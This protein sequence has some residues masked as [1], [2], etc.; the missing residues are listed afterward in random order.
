MIFLDEIKDL[1]LYNKKFYLPIDL[2]N[3]NTGSV[4][5]LLG[6]QPNQTT[7]ILKNPLLNRKYFKSY[8]IEKNI[9]IYVNNEGYM[10]NKDNLDTLLE[11]SYVDFDYIKKCNSIEEL[12]KM[13]E[14]FN[15]KIEQLDSSEW[16]AATEYAYGC[17]YIN[18]RKYQL[19]KENNSLLEESA[20]LSDYLNGEWTKEM[21]DDYNL[22]LELIKKEILPKGINICKDSI[23]ESFESYDILDGIFQMARQ[24][25][26]DTCMKQIQLN[27]MIE[28]ESKKTFLLESVINEGNI[29]QELVSD[30]F[31]GMVNNDDDYIF[32][33]EF[34]Q[35]NN[36]SGSVLFGFNDTLEILG[37]NASNNVYSRK[38]YKMLYNTRFKTPKEVFDQYDLLQ[39]SFKDIKYTY[40]TLD[41]Y[42]NKNLLLDLS[43][44]NS[45][46]FRTNTFVADKGINFYIDYLRRLI[47]DKRL[48]NYKKKTVIIPLDNSY[49]PDPKRKL[50]Y[51]NNVNIMSSFLRLLFK[52]SNKLR[53]FKDIDFIVLSDFGYFKFRPDQLIKQNI[54][55]FESLF[56]KLAKR[57]PI[58]DDEANKDSKQAMIVKVVD[59]LEKSQGI[60][61]HNLT[62]DNKDD[63][64]KNDLVNTIKKAV[65]KS[66]SS[67]EVLDNIEDEEHAKKL[68]MQA[69]ID[70]D[71]VKI[72]A[73]RQARID[74]N[75]VS[76]LDL[77]VKGKTVKDLL[78]ENKEDKE[79]PETKLEIDTINE[80][81]KH[82]KFDNFESVY[83]LNADIVEMLNDLA[84]KKY[85]IS[86]R[87]IKVEDTSTSEDT[88]ET[89]NVK[90]EDGFGKRFT[91]TFD[92]PKIVDKKYMYLRGN[93]KTI[94]GQLLLLPV[95]KTDLD[96]VQI[97]SNYK[98][99]FIRRYGLSTPG[100]TFVIADKIIKTLNK[101][102]FSELRI[103]KGNNIKSSNKYNLPIDYIDLSSVYSIIDSDKYT[104][105]F[106]QDTIY[107]E[108]GDIIKDGK[109]IP[110]GIDKT[111][112]EPIILYWDGTSG[113]C[114]GFISRLLSLSCPEFSTQYDKQK[115]STKYY[116]SQASILAS[117][118]PLIIVLAYSEGL[119][120]V[121]DKSK[122]KYEFTQKRP[123]QDDLNDVIRFNDGY[124]L[125]ENTPEASLLLNGLKECDTANYSIVDVNKKSM[126]LDFLD[127]FGGRI[128]ADG[129]DNFYELMIDSVTLDV[130]K[131][132]K[133]PTDYVSL[134]LYGNN[135]LVDNKYVMHT[136]LD[137]NRYRR[138]EIIAGYFYLCLASAYGDYATSIKKGRMDPMTIKQSAVIDAIMLDT[139]FGDKSIINA[140]LDVEDGYV[141]TT[142]GLSGMN[143]DRSYSLD[144]R[145]YNKSMLNIIALSTGFAGNVGVNRQ[146][147]ID[148][149]VEGKRGYLKID[150]N[151]DKMNVTKSLCL[152]E[153]LNPMIINSDD[154][155]RV[156]MG[157]I[158]SSKHTMRIKKGMPNLISNGADMALPYLGTDTFSF[159]AKQDGKIVE[160]NKEYMIVQYSDK[161]YDYISLK[162]NIEKNS[163][164]GVFIGIK[165]DTDLKVGQKFKTKDVLAYD[166][167]SFSKMVGH[168]G[169]LAYSSQLVPKI[170]IMT[171]DEGFE[172]ST[173]FSE[174]FSEAMAHD[175][176]IKKEITIPK[177][178]NILYMVK[179]GQPIKEG[180]SLI[181]FQDAYEDEDINILLKN[182]S[183]DEQEIS[184][185]GRIPIQS[186][187]EGT[188][189]DIKISRTVEKTE[190]SDS[191]RKVVN[192][193]EKPIKDL[194]STLNKY[195][196]PS[197]DKVDADYVLQNTGKLKNVDEGLLIEIFCKYEDKLSIGD[198]IVNNSAVKGVSKGIFPKG[199]EPWSESR[200]NEPIHVFTSV[201]G[202]SSRIV[203]SIMKVGGVNK[204][205]IELDRHVKEMAGIEWKILDD[206]LDEEYKNN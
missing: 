17:G 197:T 192:D 24:A 201:G 191:I 28:A 183:S 131:R 122:I 198:K 60:K 33:D 204:F 32:R 68:I 121:L 35:F 11:C 84:N 144:K 178:A 172:D 78:S 27:K 170:A 50:N 15:K 203:T 67:E 115:I 102:E 76:F 70:D 152:T 116:Y 30:E 154:P 120:K 86:V 129:L 185:M 184:E 99:I 130:L 174:W 55:K 77:D 156:L 2:K 145:T 44:Y 123:Q 206:I 101:N 81:W 139:T 189:Q 181:I 199:E 186:H 23:K 104:I 80:E 93:R 142:K 57:E 133:L 163:N 137:S 200:P 89:W 66:N 4:V 109:G 8:Y 95:S 87:D 48:K 176:I 187:V 147:T 155:F 40:L 94:S 112:K 41:K 164:G 165:L 161:S 148:M 124:L 75:K 175:I 100:K 202:L 37:E 134:L 61:I 117:K 58:I 39:A 149:N 54:S 190:L 22:R 64:V 46:F 171:T 196:I 103:S 168:T 141:V 20:N 105:Y 136:E 159:K 42:N 195:N 65:D 31:I 193:Y 63:V 114:S 12:E 166:R 71:P 106:N 5:M 177:D 111:S 73:T 126:Y 140:S 158:Q 47:M 49:L 43:Y 96:T 88:I 151:T 3:K 56:I 110:I 97:V 118:I 18:R 83:D 90:M 19:K 113:S 169:E 119:I 205:I 9:S 59:D 135:L 188:I 7:E 162:E 146:G 25:Q 91:F 53:Q 92:I 62:G 85:P 82:L 153:A 74:A 179:K 132:Y 180:E 26:Y 182:L 127:I 107:K 167:L 98:K 173:I 160:L 194:K 1:K 143:S 138:N 125:F 72:S 29:E 36:E 52:E 51:I 38:I 128:L 16:N 108:Y 14:L 10:I 34:V 79:L 157:F 13:K 150:P 21:E 45:A 69:A 6:N